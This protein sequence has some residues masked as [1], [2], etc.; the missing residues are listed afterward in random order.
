MG[1]ATL[2]LVV[3]DSLRMKVKQAMKSKSTDDADMDCLE[4]FRMWSL[5]GEVGSWGWGKTVLLK[6]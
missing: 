4:F 1:G 5:V 6:I 2:G 3:L